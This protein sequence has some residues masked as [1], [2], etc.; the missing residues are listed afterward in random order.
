MFF[1]TFELERIRRRV[2]GPLQLCSKAR[3]LL[4]RYVDLRRIPS[5]TIAIQK[6]RRFADRS[7]R[8]PIVRVRWVRGYDRKR[9]S[10]ARAHE[11]IAC[12]SVLLCAHARTRYLKEA[13][14]AVVATDFD[15]NATVAA[16]SIA[17]L[18]EKELM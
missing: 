9:V 17:L 3:W 15:G 2:L 13:V 10:T 11:A 8:S 4:E 1:E 18:T 12:A 16:D 6:E 14:R 5:A 7:R